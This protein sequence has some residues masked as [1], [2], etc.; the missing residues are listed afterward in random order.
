MRRRLQGRKRVILLSAVQG[1]GLALLAGQPL[2]AQPCDAVRG[3]EPAPWATGAVQPRR[4]RLYAPACAPTR[5]ALTATQL[6]AATVALGWPAVPGA[7]GYVLSW[8]YADRVPP[9]VRL[10]GRSALDRVAGPFAVTELAIAGLDAGSSYRWVV[11]A[12]GADGRPVAESEV[13]TLTLPTVPAPELT[14]SV[15]GRGVA[16]N[17]S[18]VPDAATY[19]L[20]AASG[21]GALMPDPERAALTTTHT[22]VDRLAPALYTF[23]VEARD[24]DGGYVTRSNV[25]QASVGSALPGRSDTTPELRP[26]AAP[27]AIAPNFPLTIRRKDARTVELSWPMLWGAGTFAVYQAQGATPLTFAFA[28]GTHSTTLTGLAPGV[29]YTLQVRAR[30]AADVEFAVSNPVTITPDQ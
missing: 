27:S 23:Q 18:S 6:G 16:L 17:W 24:A 22:R 7:T 14:A 3:A 5:F 20:L 25:A 8:G 4:P 10:L 13:A 11:Q 9:P 28:T 2:L 26:A 15:D 19:R 1:V 30:N 21:P 29:D 12:L